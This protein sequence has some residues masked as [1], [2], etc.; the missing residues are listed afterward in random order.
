MATIVCENLI[1]IYRNG[2]VE[3]I[4]L[5]QLSLSIREGEFRVIAGP[6]GSGKTT[7][8]NLIGGIDKPDAGVIIVDNED[9]TK[10]NYKQLMEYRRRKIGFV[11]QMFNLVPYLTALENVELPM[12]A[13]GVP[14][15]ERIKRAKE[16]LKLVG[17]EDRIDN[18]PTELSGG[19]QQRV[20]IAVALA[21]DPPIILADEPTGE[22]DFATGRQIVKLFQDLHRQ[23]NKTIVMV[24]HDV[25][26]ALYSDRIS[27]MRDG[28]IIQTVSPA[29]KDIFK[30]LLVS[31][32]ETLTSLEEKKNRLVREISNL[33]NDFK[34]GYITL[35]ELVSRYLELKNELERIEKELSKMSF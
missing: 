16:L 9:I 2:G 19:E 31:A 12:T 6:S 35:D 14:R 27:L 3:T 17:L 25:S 4:A 1:K 26:M 7:L 29:E 10:Y 13:I 11:F 30:L 20:A 21:N 28:R 22:L 8:L 24:T 32:D 18:K 15:E 5:R 23:L 34:R 33:E